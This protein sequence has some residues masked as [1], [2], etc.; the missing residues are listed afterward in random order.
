MEKLQNE[1]AILNDN[2]EIIHNQVNESHRYFNIIQNA[3]KEFESETQTEIREFIFR[4]FDPHSLSEESWK[5]TSEE[6][7]EDNEK[8]KEKNPSTP[9][10]K[11]KSL[12]ISPASYLFFKTQH[13]GL[14]LKQLFSQKN[15]IFFDVQKTWL[16]YWSANSIFSINKDHLISKN[17]RK[18]LT[19]YI[20]NFENPNEG[21]FSG[22]VGY[23]SNIISSFGAVLSLAL[24][25]CPSLWLTVDRN[26]LTNFLMKLKSF[27]QPKDVL[28][29]RLTVSLQSTKFLGTF[30]LSQ[31]GEF[32]IRNI[33]TALVCLL[34][35]SPSPRDLSTSRM[36]SSA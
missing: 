23:Q 22:G 11:I 4:N 35:T 15:Q 12:S 10:D 36:P 31:N 29:P 21:G 34:Y 27:I 28:S 20:L 8:P 32:D 9:I 17:N 6:S 13:A 33:Y 14:S 5:T 1:L 18:A 26:K 19:Q 30:R 16:I 24:F 25:Q 3:K 2:F 7:E